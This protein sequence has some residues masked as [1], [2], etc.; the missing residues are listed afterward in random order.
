MF[1]FGIVSVLSVKK[2]LVRGFGLFCRKSQG[3]GFLF[4]SPPW[5][6][7]FVDILNRFRSTAQKNGEKFEDEQNLVE[8]LQ[9]Y[10]QKMIE[11]GCYG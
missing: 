8:L 10:G 1:G 6:R 4:G 5:K 11:I 9:I 2:V 7:K 3:V